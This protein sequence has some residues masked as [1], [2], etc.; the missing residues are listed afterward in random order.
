MKSITELSAAVI[1]ELEKNPEAAWQWFSQAYYAQQSKQG[2][3]ELLVRVRQ[4]FDLTALVE[5]SQG[6]R[7]YAGKQGQEAT[8]TL[9]TLCWALLLKH[10][11]GWSYRKTDEEIGNNSLCRW[12]VGYQLGQETLSYVTLQRFQ[13]WSSQHHPRTLFNQILKQIDE[14]FPE[15]ARKAQVGDTFALLAN[16]GAQSRT[17]MLR[18]ASRRLLHFLQ[19]VQPLAYACVLGQ[20]NT[21]ELFG[22]ESDLPE[23]CLDKAERD[24]LELRTA[25]AA[26]GCLCLVWHQ[27]AALPS[28]RSLEFLA[29]QR[30]IGILDKLLRDEFVFE[31]GETENS[32]TVRPCT[33]KERGTFVIGSTID[34]EATFRKHGEKNQLGY[35]VQVAAGEHFIREIFATTGATGDASGVAS[36]IA[37][38]K[39]QLGLLPPKLIYDRAAGSPK[40]Y[41]DVAKASDGQTQLVARLIDH[42]KNSQRYGPLD[43]TL[44][45][46]GSLTC[47]NSQTTSKFYRSQSADGYNYR[48]S[49]EQCKECPLRKACRGE[50]EPPLAEA[51]A[52]PVESTPTP[53]PVSATPTQPDANKRKLPKSTAYR[54]VFISTYRDLQRSAILYT[55]TE[56]F[57]TDM[58]FRSTIEG[59]IAALVRYNDARQ[60]HAYGLQKADFQVRMAA[61][62]FNLKKWH[63][64]TLEQEKAAHY[65]VPDSS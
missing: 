6:Y 60:A 56:A 11:Q 62:A 7:V 28:R 31:A 49:A 43:F 44:N 57:K 51:T 30:W 13:I 34:P 59:K 1:I 46:D 58:Q 65:V 42:S 36:L 33:E 52:Q 64:L 63:K 4:R 45:P 3:E 35:N 24:G 39:E 15:D 23:Y 22:S 8:Y 55:K 48:F 2:A 20:L 21:R 14:D 38:Q 5:A 32:L 9:E 10:L 50:S 18:D 40:I 29:L 12:F 54:Q 41:H 26:D 47:P 37:H 16:V 53:T 19:Q 17:E 27:V 25:L 61:V